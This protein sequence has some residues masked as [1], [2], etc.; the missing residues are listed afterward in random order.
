[1]GFEKDQIEK[2]ISVLR[3]GGA[4]D[5]D[6]DSVIGSIVGGGGNPFQGVGRS[7]WEFVES[8]AQNIDNQHQLR[9]R[10]QR[11]AQTVGRSARDIWSN[12]RDESQRFRSNLL[13]TCDQADV[14]ARNAGTQVRYA[15]SSA[16]EAAYRANEEYRIAEKVATVA[17]VGGATLLALGNPRA[18]V[19][20]MAVA[21]ASLAV[22]EAM[23]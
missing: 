10:T 7:T 4:A 1:M 23:R 15:A 13:E 11:C 8:T 21:G 9:R 20:V 2:A 19:G 5:I 3:E 6:A 17:V 14:H 22:G 12:V 16:K 18:G